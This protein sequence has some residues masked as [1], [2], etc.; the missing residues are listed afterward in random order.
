MKKAY[1]HPSIK[2]MQICFGKTAGTLGKIPAPRN[3][4]L[5]I[6]SG[7]SQMQE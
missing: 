5:V 4:K 2:H 1:Q 3:V 6:K 7:L